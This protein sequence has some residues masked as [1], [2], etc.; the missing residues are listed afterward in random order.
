VPVFAPHAVPAAFAEPATWLRF[1]SLRDRVE[2]DASALGHVRAAL[3]P[4]EASLWERARDVPGD[5]RQQQAFVDAAWREVDAGLVRL[6]AER[7]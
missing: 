5:A 6:G 1:A 2:H 7:R 4:I 3:G